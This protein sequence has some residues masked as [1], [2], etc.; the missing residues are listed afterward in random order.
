MDVTEKLTPNAKLR[1]YRE[2]R[3][4]SQEQVGRAVGTDAKRVGV[5]ERGENVPSPYFRHKLCALFGKDAVELGFLAEQDTAA[6]PSPQQPPE[7]TEH[8]HPAPSLSH[9]QRLDLDGGSLHITIHLHRRETSPTSTSAEK[10]GIITLRTDSLRQVYPREREDAVNRHEFLDKAVLLSGAVLLTTPGDPVHAEL[11][12]RLSTALKK[13]SALDAVTLHGLK[14]TTESYRH[15]FV[16]GLVA[17]PALL[18]ATVGHFELVVQF[19]QDS[20]L[21]STRNAL[22]AI[23]SETAQLSAWLSVNMHLY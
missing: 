12:D 19:L 8:A 11:V 22:S 6:L 13:P 1:W 15:L 2:I 18:E 14:T 16:H 17:S 7:A 9:T 23:A 5:W 20:L 4:W 10:H 3:G 21:P